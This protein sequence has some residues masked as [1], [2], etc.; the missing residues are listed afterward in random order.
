MV[1]AGWDNAGVPIFGALPEVAVVEQ[2][3]HHCFLMDWPQ[4]MVRNHGGMSL[5]MP[6]P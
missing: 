5:E 6:V 1:L 3:V 4:Q 2:V